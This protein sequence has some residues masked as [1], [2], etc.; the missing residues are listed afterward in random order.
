MGTRRLR[1]WGAGALLTVA[2][3]AAIAQGDTSC[4]TGSDNRMVC[5]PPDGTC[6]VD[7][8][9]TVVCSNSGGGIAVDRYGEAVCGPG[10]CAKDLRGD[11]Y[12]SDAPRGSAAIDTY[13][14]AACSG[15][16]VRASREACVRPA[17]R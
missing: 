11:L 6:M 10:N 7:R 2:S 8:T 14:N 5:P 15:S 9:G 3:L 17:G 13:G 16:C 12:C 4:K 1:A